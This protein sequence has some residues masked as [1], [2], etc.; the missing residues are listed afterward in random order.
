MNKQ[1]FIELLREPSTI[2]R[3]EL[4]GLENVTRQYPYFQSAH[5]LLAKGSKLVKD[6]R[7]KQ[8]INSAALYS[9]DRVLLKKYISGDLIFLDSVNKPP[10]NVNEEKAS[11]EVEECKEGQKGHSYD[12]PACG[13]G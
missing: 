9:T 5:L 11:N 3:E 6:P 4:S 12:C 10:I 1:K 13:M 2:T 7:A 8:K